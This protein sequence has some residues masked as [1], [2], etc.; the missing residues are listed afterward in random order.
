MSIIN[1][2]ISLKEVILNEDRV[3]FVIDKLNSNVRSLFFDIADNSL[4]IS[5]KL[6]KLVDLIKELDPTSNKEYFQWIMKIADKEWKIFL[7]NNSHENE[8]ILKDE[9]VGLLIYQYSEDSDKYRNTLNLFSENKPL[10]KKDG[11]SIDINKYEDFDE[12]FKVVSIYMGK[13]DLLG[14]KKFIQTKQVEVVHEDSRYLVLIPRT[15][16]ASKFYST[17]TDWCTHYPDMYERYSKKGDL[18]I[19]ISKENPEKDR[20][21]LHFEQR[22]YMNIYDRE[23]T[24]DALSEIE[25]IINKLIIYKLKK[26]SDKQILNVLSTLGGSILL[27]N[28][29]KFDLFGL[30][31]LLKN[32]YTT[33]IFKNMF[34]RVMDAV[35]LADAEIQ[36]NAVIEFTSLSREILP[37]IDSYKV[38]DE[39]KEINLNRFNLEIG[40]INL[41]NVE[42]IDSTAFYHNSTNLA[43]VKYI[44]KLIIRKC[45]DDLK[46]KE[47]VVIDYLECQWIR[48]KDSLTL[49]KQC[50][51]KRLIS[52][53]RNPEDF[54]KIPS[55]AKVEKI[56]II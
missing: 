51:I 19:I 9:F 29:S 35:F 42:R 52:S 48:R 8:N 13:E 25:Y 39:V 2:L 15:F 6:N 41:N 12:V 7:Q 27:N 17:G 56:V 11:H 49:P 4:E 3:S 20:F 16:E 1:R 23:I 30:K 46:L 18:Y 44:K 22:Q 33:E 47:D 24:K 53:A 43:N 31:N 50:K 38:P 28:V 36:E 26:I 37:I 10:I 55:T 45:E 21:Q 54:I 34:N 14:N 40:N 5:S 32:L